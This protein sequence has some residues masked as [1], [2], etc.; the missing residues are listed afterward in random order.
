MRF[1]RYFLFA[2]AVAA[3]SFYWVMF[4]PLRNPRPD[5]PY[6]GGSFALLNARVYISPDLP[7]VDNA[8]VV[9]QKGRITQ[10]GPAV[11]VPAGIE[12]L[13]CNQ[14]VVTAGFWNTHVH[15][16]EPQFDA[17][18]MGIFPSLRVAVTEMLSSRGFTTVV[19]TGS[20]P[21]I[22]I[23]LR[24]LIEE[25][26]IHGPL[27][28]TSGLTVFPHNGI[29]YYLKKTLA[30]PALWFIPQP[31]TAQEAVRTVNSNA[32]NGAD[33][34]KLFTGSYIERGKVLPMDAAVARAAADEAHRHGQLVF[35]HPSDLAGTKVAI[36]AGVDVLAHAPDSTGG[37]DDALLKTL[38][39]RHMAMI[40]T[41]KMFSN[42]VSDA[43]AYIRPIHALV[44]KFH[45]LGG[46][47]LFGTDVGYMTDHSTMDEYTALADSGL[48]AMDILR[49]LTVAPAQRFGVSRDKGTV[50]PGKLADLV[51][52][53]EDPARDVGAFTRVRMTIRN[54]KINY[55][56][57]IR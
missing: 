26:D 24:R 21:R 14:C 41:L 37:I 53:D 9:V 55:A 1:L 11:P 25:D 13:P 2:L 31:Q 29:P 20:D 40:P 15:F 38:V 36:E 43:P 39:D 5:P 30:G 34:L 46:Q 17:A 3:A 54:G 4:W 27:I 48:N 57:S 10:V 49:S 32:G 6:G 56:S 47:I 35:A 22:S 42:T 28:Y 18:R 50:E 19:D 16:T 33:I 52:L 12:R 44:A 7:P 51:V 8:T 23:S 45:Q